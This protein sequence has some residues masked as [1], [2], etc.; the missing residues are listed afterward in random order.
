MKSPLLITTLIL[1]SFVLAGCGG[2]SGDSKRLTEAEEQISETEKE[3]A[4][5]KKKTEAA[6]AARQRAEVARQAA[7]AA[8]QREQTAREQAE[9]ERDEQRAEADAAQLALNRDL[10]RD[11]DR[12]LRAVTADQPIVAGAI[13]AIDNAPRYRASA[14][15][16]TTPAISQRTTATGSLGG[17][18][19]T[20]TSGRDEANLDQLD[21]Y[22][23]VEA[24]TPVPF[25]DSDYNMDSNNVIVDAEGDVVSAHTIVPADGEHTEASAFPRTSGMPTGFSLPHRGLLESA[26]SVLGLNADGT[27]DEEALKDAGITRAQYNQYRNDRGFRNEAI[28]PFRY[29]YT[30]SGTLQGASGTYRCGAASGTGASPCTVQNRGEHFVFAG[31]W[32]FR[33]TSGTTAVRVPDAQFMYFGWWSPSRQAG[34]GRRLEIPDFPW[35]HR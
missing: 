20:S 11:V 6:E 3:L 16:G 24:P 19:K 18:F 34:Y 22:S 10:A 4:E 33:P 28:H 14:T 26:Y 13:D 30:T 25:K 2:G 8:R 23:N 32:T 35:S 17:W 7:E 5:A 9:R 21:V 12:G 31:P 27:A 29:T 1:G 15:V